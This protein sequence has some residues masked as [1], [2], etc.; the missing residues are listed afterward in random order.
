MMMFSDTIIDF[1]LFYDGSVDIQI[2]ALLT[3]CQCKVS[4]TQVTVKARGLLVSSHISL[5]FFAWN[6]ATKYT[7]CF[8]DLLHLP[9]ECM[10]LKHSFGNS[11]TDWSKNM[12]IQKAVN[13]LHSAC[14]LTKNNLILNII[15]TDTLW[16]FQNKK[17]DI[18]NVYKN[19]NHPFTVHAL[20]RFIDIYIHVCVS[21][22]RDGSRLYQFVLFR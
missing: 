16:V 5:L 19:D 22:S 21:Q 2:R 14:W 18:P 6:S 11:F 4:V 17:H 1:Y 15:V 8:C 7:K 13:C 12:N 3:R 10:L 20:C 9:L